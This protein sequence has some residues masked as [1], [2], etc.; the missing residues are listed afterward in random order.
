MGRQANKASNEQPAKVVTDLRVHLHKKSRLQQNTTAV[1]VPVP[2]PV[3]ESPEP[4]AQFESDVDSLE[5]ARLTSSDEDE[6]VQEQKTNPTASSRIILKSLHKGS[7]KKVGFEQ[8]T[9]PKKRNLTVQRSVMSRLGA[10]VISDGDSEEE[11]IVKRK[12]QKSSEGEEDLD[13]NPQPLLA[14]SKREKKER[15]KK[16]KKKKKKQQRSSSSDEDLDL[17]P[18][19]QKS[20]S[21]SD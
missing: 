21:A 10:K 15:K 6:F 12:V 1:S 13:L 14:E 3:A 18:P 8:E 5:N 7:P 4:E 20:K 2:V 16:E 17:N 19:P 9:L 11:I